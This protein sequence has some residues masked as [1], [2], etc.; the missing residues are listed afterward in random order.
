[1][2]SFLLVSEWQQQEVEVAGS[3]KIVHYSETAN[4]SNCSVE[5]LTLPDLYFLL[6]EYDVILCFCS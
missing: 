5:I 2:S 1:M 3:P 4:Q 6:K